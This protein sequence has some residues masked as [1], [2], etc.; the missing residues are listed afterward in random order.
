MSYTLKC[1]QE[2]RKPPTGNGTESEEPTA[3]TWWSQKW[4]FLMDETKGGR[5]SIQPPCLIAS[6][7]GENPSVSNSVSPDSV[8]PDS[9]TPEPGNV[10]GNV[11]DRHLVLMMPKAHCMTEPAF[12]WCWLNR[13]LTTPLTGSL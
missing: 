13:P 6:A 2:Q 3:G 8:P 1:A 12:A 7:W 11:T 9:D 10:S 4:F 5:P